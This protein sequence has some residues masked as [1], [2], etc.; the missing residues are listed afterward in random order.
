LLR[1]AFE[2]NIEIDTDNFWDSRDFWSHFEI[3]DLDTIKWTYNGS[4]D[5]GELTNDSS[6][7]FILT[8]EHDIKSTKTID[9]KY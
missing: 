4:E 9:T 1:D 7:T 2:L 5:Q 3:E 6:V 8:T